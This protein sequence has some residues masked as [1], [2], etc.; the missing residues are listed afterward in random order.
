MATSKK[1]KKVDKKAQEQV[2]EVRAFNPTKSGIG[3]IIILILALGMFLGLVIAAV[4][5][6]I[7]V[8]SQ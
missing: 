7:Q 2:K 1:R 6:I 5:N 8:L 3:R 4:I